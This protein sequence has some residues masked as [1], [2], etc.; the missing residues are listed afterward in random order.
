MVRVNLDAFEEDFNG[1]LDGLIADVTAEVERDTKGMS[2]LQIAEYWVASSRK[3][4]AEVERLYAPDC[5]IQNAR[6]VLARREAVLA[7]L[8]KSSNLETERGS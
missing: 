2:E 8:Q 1:A 5:I 6:S 7:D 4:L 3:H